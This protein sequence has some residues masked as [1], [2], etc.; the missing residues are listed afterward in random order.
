VLSRWATLPLLVLLPLLWRAGLAFAWCATRD[1]R[2]TRLLAPCAVLATWL[3]AIHAIGLAAHSFYAGLYGATIL[4]AVL[5][6]RSSRAPLP[7]ARTG[8]WMLAGALVAVLVLV[9][10]EIYY[11]KHDECLLTG[12]V[13]IPAEI[14]NGVYPPHHLTFPN[15]ELR[16]HYGIDLLDAVVSSLLGRLDLR[17][18]VHLVALLLWGYSFC[19]Y[20]HLGQSL[21]GHRAAGPVTACCVLFAGGAPLLCGDHDSSVQYFTSTCSA[22]GTWITPP[23]VSNFLQHPWT[24]GMPLFGATLLLVTCAAKGSFSYLSHWSWGLLSVLVA[25]LSLSQVVLFACFVPAFVV[26]GA[27]D[28]RRIRAARLGR[29]LVWGATMGLAAR[30]LHGMFAPTAEPAGARALFHPFWLDAPFKDWLV[31]H[32]ESFGALL[33]LGILGFFC[34][35]EQ[36][37]LL[38]LMAAGSLLVRDLFRYTPSWNIVKFAM[39]SQI[40]LAI[41]AS[42]ALAWAFARGG[43]WRIAGAAGLVASTFF[44]FAW[45][46]ALTWAARA[47]HATAFSRDCLPPPPEG[48]DA[49]AI[50]F[51]R[52]HAAAGEGVYRSERADAYAMYGGLP[53]PT[54]DWGTLSFGFSETLFDERRQLSAAP[55]DLDL[56]RAQGFRWIVVAPHDGPRVAEAARRWTEEHRAVLFAEFPPLKVYR[57]SLPSQ[58]EGDP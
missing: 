15:Y 26:A 2:L 23:F 6:A 28:G 1:A 51:L 20:W 55:D 14:Q 16:Y 5:G 11:S 17:A 35:R 25:A 56:A 30:L 22:G 42:A 31:W 50:D 39:V 40:A 33:P 38:A 37:V 36:R 21:A 19:L 8:R 46:I 29:L 13:S 7:A 12:H 27:F 47:A 44:G 53:Q 24:L 9:G 45:P 10:P 4:L 41:L 3:L 57:L 32:A 34:L 52:R 58:F 48:A 49:E 43:R 18:T 54:W